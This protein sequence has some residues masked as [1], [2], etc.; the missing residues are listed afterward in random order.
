[1]R[2]LEPANRVRTG[3]LAITLAVLATGVG[4]TFTSIPQLFAQ[5]RYFAEFA[6][7]G[8]LHAGDKVRISG[9]DVGMVQE[10][11]IA[12]GRIVVQFGMGD[13]TIGTQSRLSI[14]TDTILGRKVLE[15][16]PKGDRALEPGRRVPLSQTTT[17]YQIYDAFQ[18]ATKAAEGWDVSTIKQSLHV[19]SQTVDQTYPH[20]SAALDG[21][22]RF[23]DTIGKRDERIQHLLGETSKVAGVL[24]IHGEQLNRLLV[25]AQTLLVAINQRSQ[26]V[27]ALVGNVGAV[28]G[29]LQGLINDN[30]NINSVLQQVNTISDVLVKRKDDLT[31]TV[32]ELGGFVASLNEI[33]S[34][35]PFV[36]AAIFNL[37]PYQMLQPWVDAAFKKRGIDPENFWRDAGLPAFRFP[38]PNGT[39]LPNG[40]P[41]PSPQVLEGT[42]SHPSP[43]VPPG[44][45]CSYAPPADGLPRPNNPLPCAALSTG[46]FGGD[47]PFPAP[48]DVQTSAPKPDGLPPTPGIP[49]AGPHGAPAPNL[50]GTPVP[51]PTKAPPG[52]RVEGLQPAGP[53]P[54]PSTF[55]PALPPGPPAPPGPGP[56]L[57]IGTGG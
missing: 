51:L 18:D 36:K 54:P 6:D 3:I 44:S 8:A 29:Q 39:R 35:G 25:N 50:P 32:R 45:P 46:P 13:N 38:D 41:P 49:I 24:G 26:A 30:P 1:M 56:Q 28:S 43:A 47:T 17:P 20:L 42:A 40:A 9:I 21:V 19:L 48:V 22:Q 37:L 7:A 23:A 53:P 52:A 14:R 2:I 12:T 27:D 16:E 31:A 15:I 33:A 11:K 55:A 57:P 5:P 4:Q 34:S 10:L